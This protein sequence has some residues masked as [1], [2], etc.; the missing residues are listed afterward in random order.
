MYFFSGGLA[1]ASYSYYKKVDL[2][3]VHDVLETKSVL[4]VLTK[5]DQV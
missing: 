5:I 1:I 3:R 4:D 2:I